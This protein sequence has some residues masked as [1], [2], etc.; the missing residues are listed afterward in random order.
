[1]LKVYQPDKRPPRRQCYLDTPTRHRTAPGASTIME[2][3]QLESSRR[4]V[5]LLWEPLFVSVLGDRRKPYEKLR[6][7]CSYTASSTIVTA[8]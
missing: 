2:E 7:V 4:F 6:M 3:L 5:S 8:R 1:V